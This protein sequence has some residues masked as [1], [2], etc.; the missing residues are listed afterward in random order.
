VGRTAA[1]AH[2]STFRLVILEYG[3]RE[4][5]VAVAGGWLDGGFSL[6]STVSLFPITLEGSHGR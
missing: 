2:F 5:G 1:D 4:G 3:G 6:T